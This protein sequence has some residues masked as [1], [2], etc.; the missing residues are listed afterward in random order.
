MDKS[1]SF[2]KEVNKDGEV[3]ITIKVNSEKFLSTKEKVYNK[4][5]QK[6]TLPGFRPGKAPRAL[7]EAQIS[8][9][10]YDETLNRLI[11]EI[12]AEILEETKLTPLNQVHYDLVKFTDTEGVEFKAKFVELPEIKLPDFSKIK[13]KK[14]EKPVKDEDIATEITKIVQYYKNAAKAQEP[15]KESGKDRDKEAVK[16]PEIKAADINDEMIK[17]LNLGFNSLK[18][19]QEQVKKELENTNKKNSEIAW[20]DGIIKEAV[21]LS[22]IQAPKALINESVSAKEKDY[23]KKLEEL[24]LKVDEFLK[25]QNTTIEKLREG[26][27]KETESRF[28]EELLLLHI[29]RDQ[30]ILIKDEEIN[31]ELAKITDEKTK[32]QLETP[33]GKRYLVTVLLQQRAIEWLKNQINK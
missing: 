26:W 2:T 28:S 13:V 23:I 4:L 10:V 9:K 11:P 19:L 29:I 6:V 5:S 17:S 21:K 7:I 16:E 1:Y 14:E 8:S 33:E 32:S 15:K 25:V 12:T 3:E 30:K 24:N 18:D 27:V 31:A 20:L 22:K